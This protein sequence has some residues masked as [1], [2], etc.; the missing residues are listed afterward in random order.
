MLAAQALEGAGRRWSGH[1]A[2]DRRKAD[3]EASTTVLRNAISAADHEGH[4]ET[5]LRSAE[6]ALTLRQ[7]EVISVP[8]DNLA[9]QPGKPLQRAFQL[10]AERQ[11]HPCLAREPHR[12]VPLPWVASRSAP[13]V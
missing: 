11:S 10:P 1:R 12:T 6:E 7:T 5:P 9:H 4:Y 3:S 13:M 2:Q 8:W